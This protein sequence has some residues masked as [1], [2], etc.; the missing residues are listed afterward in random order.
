[1]TFGDNSGTNWVF[2]FIVIV[3]L[4]GYGTVYSSILSSFRSR[5][6]WEELYT[7]SAAA[8][9]ILG[10]L[11]A[12]AFIVGVTAA[13]WTAAAFVVSGSPFLIITILKYQAQKKQLREFLN[14]TTVHAKS[15]AVTGA[16]KE[17][18]HVHQTERPRKQRQSSRQHGG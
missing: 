3:L 18:P 15:P 9:Y 1:M 10:T 12:V 17:R 13:L 6:N 5:F 4:A 8:I 7:P 2:I 11:A 14:T 16:N